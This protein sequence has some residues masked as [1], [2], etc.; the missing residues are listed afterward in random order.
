MYLLAQLACD[1]AATSKP[2][3]NLGR[4]AE[5]R[6][7]GRVC[8]RA[9]VQARAVMVFFFAAERGFCS[10]QAGSGRSLLPPERASPV[11]RRVWERPAPTVGPPK[12]GADWRPCGQ[13]TAASDL[14]LSASS[15]ARRKHAHR[16]HG[17]EINRQAVASVSFLRD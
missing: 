5:G 15:H 1:W 3:T 11:P 4:P 12:H 8:R 13:A 2:G 14:W 9:G 7:G 10:S 16:P 17:A 6:A